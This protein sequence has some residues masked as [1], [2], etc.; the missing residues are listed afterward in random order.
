MGKTI[1]NSLFKRR[2]PTIK[3]SAEQI[4]PKNVQ[5]FQE[6][7]IP[8]GTGT[9]FPSTTSLFKPPVL[10][11]KKIGKRQTNRRKL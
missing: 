5:K 9:Y 10:G 3:G 7:W 1:G 2:S 4:L 6:T 11:V 8:V